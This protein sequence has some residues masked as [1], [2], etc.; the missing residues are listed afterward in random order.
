MRVIFLVPLFLTA[1]FAA[2]NQLA[3]PAPTTVQMPPSA[4]PEQA[5]P[6]AECTTDAAKHCPPP[7]P[8]SDIDLGDILNT[9]DPDGVI[10]L[11][12]DGLRLLDELRRN[13]PSAADDLIRRLL[14]DKPKTK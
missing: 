5:D 8:G 7:G 13:D 3:D 2:E 6:K 1:G 4:V 14:G 12:P 9:S 10:D 11:S